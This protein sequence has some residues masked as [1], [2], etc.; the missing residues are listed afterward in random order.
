[1]ERLD[2]LHPLLLADREIRDLASRSRRC[3]SARTDLRYGGVRLRAS[4]EP[5]P[6]PTAMFSST[7]KRGTS[8]KCWWTMPMPARM[9]SRGDRRTRGTPSTYAPRIRLVEAVKAG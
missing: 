3:R 9:A 7:E 1:M 8:T 5:L 4:G 2:D 6:V